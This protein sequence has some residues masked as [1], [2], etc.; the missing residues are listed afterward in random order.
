MSKGY[1]T[2]TH[3]VAVLHVD[4]LCYSWFTAVLQAKN[5]PFKKDSSKK[6]AEDKASSIK[7]NDKRTSTGVKLANKWVAEKDLWLI[8][9][10]SFFFLFF[11]KH[12]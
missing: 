12:I 2:T 1:V 5:D 10:L 7:S 8:L 3:R 4:N 6:E 9:L 11:V